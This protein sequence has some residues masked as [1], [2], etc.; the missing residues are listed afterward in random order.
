[1]LQ[2][3]VARRLVAEPGTSAYGALSIWCRV[4]G[5]VTRKVPVS[6]EAF[7]P[8]TQGRLHAF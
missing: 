7:T 4:Y 3:E 1:M 8:Q 5:Q 6:P 2:K